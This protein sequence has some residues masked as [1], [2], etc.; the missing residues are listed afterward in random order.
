MI[1]LNTLALSLKYIFNT[2]FRCT[3]LSI[4]LLI[5]ALTPFPTLT[6]ISIISKLFFYKKYHCFLSALLAGPSP[7]CFP[8]NKSL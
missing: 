1:I 2:L 4:M 5:S 8:Q 6:E 3:Y 7:L